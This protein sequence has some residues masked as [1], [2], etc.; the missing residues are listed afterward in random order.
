MGKGVKRLGPVD[1]QKMGDSQKRSGGYI[2]VEGEY[3]STMNSTR[4]LTERMPAV[5]PH[6]PARPP[7]GKAKYS[8]SSTDKYACHQG[9]WSVGSDL[10]Q[11]N[12]MATGAR[13]VFA[14]IV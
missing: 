1:Q 5:L 11:M 8:R 7:T 2:R 10:D 14:I 12:V 3:R 9:E 13:N 4:Y 6:G